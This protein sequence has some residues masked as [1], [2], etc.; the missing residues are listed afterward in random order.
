[1]PACLFALQSTHHQASRAA[2]TLGN[3]SARPAA[4]G[5]GGWER[6]L[7]GL[8]GGVAAARSGGVGLVY[9]EL[10]MATLLLGRSWLRRSVFRCLVDAWMQEQRLPRQTRSV[11]L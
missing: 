5:Q 10:K 8:A 9:A 2:G 1:M 3:A 11:L 4:A 6:R 7:Q